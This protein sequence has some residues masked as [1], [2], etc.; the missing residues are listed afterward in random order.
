VNKGSAGGR[1]TGFDAETYKGRNVVERS[2]NR[3]SVA[4]VRG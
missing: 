4:A 3:L 1:P 2:F